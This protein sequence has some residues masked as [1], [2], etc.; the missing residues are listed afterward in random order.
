VSKSE[1]NEENDILVDKDKMKDYQKAKLEKATKAYEQECLM[2]FST[3][4]TGGVIKKFDFPALQPLTEAQRENKVLDMVHQ[5]VGHAFVSHKPIMTNSIHNVVVNTLHEGGL[6][7]YMGQAY[8]QASQMFFSHT[9]SATAVPP[10]VPQSQAEGSIGVS[11][12]IGST[13]P[14]QC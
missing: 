4:R 11:Q 3:T 1:F 6:Q 2:S 12:P 9:G 13:G 8:Q 14:P 7:G 5:A 10:V